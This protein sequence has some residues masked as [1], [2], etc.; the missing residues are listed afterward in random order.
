MTATHAKAT[1]FAPAT[2]RRVAAGLAEGTG[3][4]EALR[5]GVVAGTI[6]VAC[7][8]LATGQRGASQQIA[9]TPP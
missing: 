9:S 5:L 8:G 2:D 4:G 3:L 6:N 7:R 1:V